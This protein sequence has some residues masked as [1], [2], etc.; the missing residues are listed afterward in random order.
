MGKYSKPNLNRPDHHRDRLWTSP[1]RPRVPRYALRHISNPKNIHL[2]HAGGCF[3]KIIPN[4]RIRPWRILSF[5][6]RI[7]KPFYTKFR[8]LS[9]LAIRH[10]QH[11]DARKKN[12]SRIFVYLFCGS[13]L[14]L[15]LTRT[16]ASSTKWRTTDGY[17][18][19]SIRL[20]HSRRSISYQPLV[21][22]TY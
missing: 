3:L 20:P 10:S 5:V 15:S 4:S 19:P 21:G 17:I 13:F 8:E 16:Q 12:C 1:E 7:R 14:S 22:K 18:N 2:H 9:Y 6:E 11:N